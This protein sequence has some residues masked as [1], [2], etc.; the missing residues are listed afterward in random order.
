[1]LVAAVRIAVTPSAAKRPLAVPASVGP[2][3]SVD[4]T[5]KPCRPLAVVAAFPTPH[6]LRQSS[7]ALPM[8][9]PAASGPVTPIELT[10]A[11][12]TPLA[13]CGL[14]RPSDALVAT[15]SRRPHGPEIAD[16][17]GVARHTSAL[18]EAPVAVV[19]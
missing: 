15:L 19:A 10:I 18:A 6:S 4:E 9:L 2:V 16:S 11:F 3:P 17:N 12:L 7:F 5:P 13:P 14:P 8:V 1:M